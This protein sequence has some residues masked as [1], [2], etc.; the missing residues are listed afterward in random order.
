M[1]DFLFRN[2]LKDPEEYARAK[3]FWLKRVEGIAPPGTWDGYAP[4]AAE[5]F[6]NGVPFNNG[7]PMVTVINWRAGR[8]VRI[9]Q[10]DPDRFGQAYKTSFG[11]V[12]LFSDAL[13]KQIVVKEK[14]ILLTLQESTLRSALEAMKI[15]LR[16]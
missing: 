6:A 16:W 4:Y 9:V 8:A 7:N 14:V 1:S 12:R 5:R 13:K 11:S 10:L 15:W 3:D 2:F